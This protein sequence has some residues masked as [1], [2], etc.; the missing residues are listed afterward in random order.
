[1]ADVVHKQDE[2]RK[3]GD[4]EID[5]DVYKEIINELDQ[6]PRAKRSSDRSAVPPHWIGESR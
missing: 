1:M 6:S 3:P 2:V 5:P 4:L